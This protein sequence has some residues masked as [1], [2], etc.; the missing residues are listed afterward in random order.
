MPIYWKKSLSL[1]LECM[2]IVLGIN[3]LQGSALIRQ[4]NNLD[5]RRNLSCKKVPKLELH[6]I[7]KEGKINEL[8]LD[9][10]CQG[11]KRKTSNMEK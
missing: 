6:Q 2:T 9:K 8:G 7:G 1:D 10:S 4:C 3:F 5:S 11:F